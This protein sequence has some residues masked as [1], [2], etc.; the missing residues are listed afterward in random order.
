MAW[1]SVY[2]SKPA[3]LSLKDNKLVIAQEE[4]AYI[5]LEDIDTLTIDNPAVT[6]T[7]KLVNE[8]ARHN[9]ATI[10]CDEKHLPCSNLIPISQHS[11]QA[12]IT[13]AQINMSQPLRK[14]LW[15][16]IVK[17]KI[18]NQA[19]VLRRFGYSDEAA[20]L[21][22]LAFLVKSG[23]SDNRESI[24]ARIYFNALLDDSTRRKPTWYNSALNYGY[25]IV[26]SIV[27]RSLVERGLVPAY[28]LF[29]HNELNNFNLA[30]DIIEPYRAVVDLYIL[31]EIATKD[32]PIDRLDKSDR[33]A[34][35]DIINKY[36]ILADRKYSVSN[37]IGMTAESLVGAILERDAAKLA[38]PT[39][40]RE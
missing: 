37:A 22:K 36:V 26:R 6:L 29:H 1:R 28:G 40:P 13:N 20:Q 25:A 34:I 3:K 15:Q 19:E 21:D 17:Q 38:L 11:R 16:R 35:L 23:D 32:A 24:A 33:I 14:Q 5:P 4:T 39:L 9:I 27:A 10:V 7:V 12:K 30:D 31:K 2:I 18:A 8:L